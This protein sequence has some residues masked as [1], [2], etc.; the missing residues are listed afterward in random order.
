MCMPELVAYGAVEGPPLCVPK[1]AFWV[2]EGPPLF[3]L[4]AAGY[5]V[6]EGFPFC[7][8]GERVC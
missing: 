8:P 4:E 7:V 5:W 1:V 6:G 3:M 2:E